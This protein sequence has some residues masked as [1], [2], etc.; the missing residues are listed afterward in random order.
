MRLLLDTFIGALVN[1]LMQKLAAPP[2]AFFHIALFAALLGAAAVH[3]TVVAGFL[4]GLRKLTEG[5]LI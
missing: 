1:F 4:A 3:A 2:F 5:F